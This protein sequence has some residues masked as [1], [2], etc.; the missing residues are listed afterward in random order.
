MNKRR[1]MDVEGTGRQRSKKKKGQKKASR[2]RGSYEEDY[3]SF[4]EKPPG[5][6]R[7][8]GACCTDSGVLGSGVLSL[9]RG[10]PFRSAGDAKESLGLPS[11]GN[12]SQVYIILI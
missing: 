1:D 10:L 8:L 5:G 3:H 11:L 12:E 7:C 6:T 4:V 2:W 9:L